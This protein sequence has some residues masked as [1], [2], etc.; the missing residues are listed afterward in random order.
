[1][2]LFP[3]LRKELPE[4]SFIAKYF[5]AQGE[6]AIY[7]EPR[8]DSNPAELLASVQNDPGVVAKRAQEARLKMETVSFNSRI[9]HS[10]TCY[11]LSRLSKY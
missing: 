3:F 7:E 11:S 10:T 6:P 4:E 5:Q 9:P 1:M 2:I 8:A